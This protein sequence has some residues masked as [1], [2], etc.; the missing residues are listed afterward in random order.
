MAHWG[1][2]W[3]IKKKYS[4][5]KITSQL[6][7]IDAFQLYKNKKAYGFLYESLN[8]LAAPDGS[9]LKVSYGKDRKR[10]YMIPIKQVSC[11]YGG[12]R[13]FFACPLCHKHMRFLY[14]AERSCLFLCRKCLNLS[15]ESQQ[16]RPT[17]RF[18]YMANK[19]THRISQQGGNVDL[20][21]KPPQVH[22]ATYRA[23]CEKVHIY[24]KKSRSALKHDIV[25]WFGPEKAAMLDVI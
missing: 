4:A 17:K 16:L 24:T 1:W 22:H 19:I 21:K 13:Y 23:L 8:M 3:Q 11:N 5:K 6:S 14:H 10:S 9:H 7:R 2:Y 20:G 15:Y 25:Q 18:T 12:F